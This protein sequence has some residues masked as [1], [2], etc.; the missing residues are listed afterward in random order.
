M[1][2]NIKGVPKDLSKAKHWIKEANKNPNASASTAELAKAGLEY[3]RAI[4]QASA[5]LLILTILTLSTAQAQ[6]CF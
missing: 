6:S 3:V 5:L 1:Y 4:F 2:A